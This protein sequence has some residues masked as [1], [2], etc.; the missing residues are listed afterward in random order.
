MP[1]I[2]RRTFL[3][4]AASALAGGPAWPQAPAPHTLTGRTIEGTGYTLARDAG[5][6]VMV[7]FWSTACAVCRDKMP[8]LRQNY[9]GW[10]DKGFQIVAVSLDRSAEEVRSYARILDSVVPMKQQFPM[11]WRGDPAHRDS[12]GAIERTPT[13][14]VLDRKGQL[15]KVFRGR[16]GAE[17]WDDVAELVLL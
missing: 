6:V 17:L 12:F 16:I 2:D 9:L 14:F 7:F 1:A 5:Q 11:L 10:R 13:T 3:A 15:A 8:E 4:A